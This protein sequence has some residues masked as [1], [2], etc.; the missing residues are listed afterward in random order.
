[1]GKKKRGRGS[2][3]QMGQK[4]GSFNNT[5]PKHPLIPNHVSLVFQRVAVTLRT[6]PLYPQY[7]SVPLSGF[8]NLSQSLCQLSC[9][10][11]LFTC[12][13]FFL[14]GGVFLAWQLQ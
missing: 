7:V 3:G 11:S 13:S 1:M 4:G 10:L 9:S 12:V 14:G 6:L 5:A 8:E 2:D